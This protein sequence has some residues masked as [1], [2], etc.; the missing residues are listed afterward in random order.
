MFC[1]SLDM[2]IIPRVCIALSMREGGKGG[3]RRIQGTE[4][5]VIRFVELVEGEIPPSGISCQGQERTIGSRRRT[6]DR[7]RSLD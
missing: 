7:L 5:L 3:H 2:V 4:T 6:I 1:S